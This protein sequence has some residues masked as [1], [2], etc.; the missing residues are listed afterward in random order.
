MILFAKDL[1][2]YTYGICAYGGE[3]VMKIF[4][5]CPLSNVL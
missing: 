5:L 2:I 1:P 4:D 3:R